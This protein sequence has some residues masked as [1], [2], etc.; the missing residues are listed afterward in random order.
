M[1]G[2]LESA[3]LD[4]VICHAPFVLR[5]GRE[6]SERGMPDGVPHRYPEH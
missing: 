3:L 2:R 1:G 5:K 4:R 6:R